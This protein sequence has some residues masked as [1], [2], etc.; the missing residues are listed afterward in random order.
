MKIGN[1]DFA[2]YLKVEGGPMFW[3]IALL[4]AR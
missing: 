1:I 4:A 3:G 2:S